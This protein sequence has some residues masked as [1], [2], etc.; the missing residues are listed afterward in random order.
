[1]E[2][3]G[4]LIFRSRAE[5]RREN[6]AREGVYVDNWFVRDDKTQLLIIPY[7]KG[8]VLNEK[9][10]DRIGGMKGPDGGRTKV[11]E[12]S[13]ASLL[14]GMGSRTQTLCHVK[15]CCITDSSCDCTTPNCVYSWTC[16]ACRGAS[17]TSGGEKE[18]VYI[19]ILVF[20]YTRG[21]WNT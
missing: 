7:T 3:G 19:G 2:K 1:M 6:V 13:G 8:G 11:V 4:K 17:T 16:N 15:D 10:M 9:E 5:I 14:T 18:M 12:R 20:L 21:L